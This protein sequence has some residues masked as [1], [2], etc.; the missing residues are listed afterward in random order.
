MRG[1]ILTLLAGA[2]SGLLGCAVI[3][4][5]LAKPNGVGLVYS[6]P[7]GRVLL[8]AQR[9]WITAEDVAAAQRAAK[10]AEDL[11]D[12]DRKALADAKEKLANDR[13]LL[14]TLNAA[15]AGTSNIK[16]KVQDDVAV[17]AA[18]VTL[19][20]AKLAIDEQ[21]AEAAKAKAEQ[22]AK[23]K[24]SLQE[25]ATL[26]LLPVF[27]DPD[28]MHRYIAN[29]KH[30]ITRDD[31][32]KIS[33]TNGLLTS[34]DVTS[35]DQSANII[36][37]L[38]ADIVLFAG[39]PPPGLLLPKITKEE[40][41]KKGKPTCPPYDFA[42]VFDPSDKQEFESVK[43]ELGDLSGVLTLEIQ[44]PPRDSDKKCENK[45]AAPDA[46]R[47]VKPLPEDKECPPQD[48]L[49]Y[50]TPTSV[51][52]Y[53]KV[54]REKA[55]SEACNMKTLPS[56]QALLAVVPDSTTLYRLSSKAGAFVT[57]TQNIAFKEGMPTSYSYQSP[58]ELL[59]FL[60]IPVNIAKTIV[61][62]PAQI[63]QARIN[64]DTQ[65]SAQLN[66]Q[67]EYLKAQLAAL[68]AKRALD[69]ARVG[70]GTAP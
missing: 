9:K 59:A 42:T 6:L 56:A 57:T 63:L 64:Y 14:E 27:P 49:F 4:S 33:V 3:N 5:D 26:T 68:Q 22:A 62:V 10:D 52:V 54:D 66:A 19:L 18:M 67:V 40:K 34:S 44:P 21:S 61:S 1:L 50:R 25:T 31:N 53:M 16:A 28:P 32:T 7:K 47:D 20:T 8:K 35:T 15:S 43:K 13:N 11:V 60:G 41:E 29:P 58:S 45:L 46:T 65:A 55:E 38:A 24:G 30:L 48:G 36:A 51:Q 37:Q 23:S 69:A 12:K 17:D 70:N 39:G 2:I